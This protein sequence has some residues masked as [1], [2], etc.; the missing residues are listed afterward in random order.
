MELRLDLP[1]EV[2][3]ALGKKALEAVRARRSRNAVMK[4]GVLT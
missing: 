2:V 4:P 1:R 3:E